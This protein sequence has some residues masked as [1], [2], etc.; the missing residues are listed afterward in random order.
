MWVIFL[1]N[2]WPNSGLVLLEDKPDPDLV[3]IIFT[4]QPLRVVRVLFSTMACGWAGGKKVCLGCIS[5]TI[6]CRK[7]K[8]GRDIGWEVKYAMSWCDLDLTFDLIV[9]TLSLRILSRLYLINCKVWEIETWYNHWLGGV[10]LQRHGVTL[11]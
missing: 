3:S 1:H 4:P 7:V 6:R 5:E 8:L 2:V 10:S 9:V 11:I